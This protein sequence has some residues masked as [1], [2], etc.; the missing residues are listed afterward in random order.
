[1]RRRSGSGA[2]AVAAAGA[3][4]SDA[5]ALDFGAGAE[6]VMQRAVAL[7]DC[8]QYCGGCHGQEIA[9]PVPDAAR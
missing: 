8:W 2:G 5:P 6:V 3:V 1:M 4:A 7:L 9:S